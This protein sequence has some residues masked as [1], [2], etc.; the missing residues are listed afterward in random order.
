MSTN[1]RVKVITTA[2]NAIPGR[3]NVYHDIFNGTVSE[4]KLV[5]STLVGKIRKTR[6]APGYDAFVM[7]ADGSR[8]SLGN[9]ATPSKAS[10]AARAAFSDTVGLPG[11]PKATKTPK[12][13]PKATP[14]AAPATLTD[15]EKREKRN[16][17][18]RELRA[19]KKDAALKAA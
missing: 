5:S 10:H 4:G 9:F 1:V 15:D 3:S 18:K 14:A 13:T 12:A 7:K 17:R 19:E 16:A 11:S 6:G 2:T 8:T